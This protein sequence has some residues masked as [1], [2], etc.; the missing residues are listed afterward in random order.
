MRIGTYDIVEMVVDD[1]VDQYG[2]RFKPTQ[3][4]SQAMRENCIIIDRLVS[5][6]ECESAE[7]EI[8]RNAMK[9]TISVV[10]MDIVL[11]YGRTHPFFSLIQN[12]ESFSFSEFED[13]LRIS[14][15]FAG[16]WDNK[17]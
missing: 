6:F 11:E 5:E 9:L 4:A 3:M 8:D 16:L 7:A 12:V 2:D 15:T 17:D 1:A 10:C 14:F 13:S